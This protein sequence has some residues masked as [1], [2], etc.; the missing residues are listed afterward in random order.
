[1]NTYPCDQCGFQG[2]DLVAIKDHIDEYHGRRLVEYP[3][4]DEEEDDE[5]YT[6]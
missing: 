4:T 2:E 3:D 6:D 1:M 5:E